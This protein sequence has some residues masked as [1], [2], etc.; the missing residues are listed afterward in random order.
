MVV[1]SFFVV[2]IHI[3]SKYQRALNASN[4]ETSTNECR[5]NCISLR[6]RPV[7]SSV[8]CPRCL[9]TFES[10]VVVICRNVSSRLFP[11]R[12]MWRSKYRVEQVSMSLRHDGHDPQRTQLYPFFLKPIFQLICFV[13]L[14]S[15]RRRRRIDGIFFRVLVL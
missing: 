12:A 9:L 14:K 8:S 5:S 15:S 4:E 6:S 10:V 3:S 2:I 11:S 13:F 1:A 7:V